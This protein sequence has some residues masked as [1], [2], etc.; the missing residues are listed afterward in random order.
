MY[1]N[2]LNFPALQK[3]SIV[4][5]FLTNVE[6]IQFCDGQ[7]LLFGYD[8]SGNQILKSRESSTIKFEIIGKSQACFGDTLKFSTSNG[9]ATKWENGAVEINHSVRIV[10]DTIIKALISSNTFCESSNSLV[11]KMNDIPAKPVISRKGD[12]LSIEN[13]PGEIKWYK[14]GLL[15]ETGKKFIITHSVAVYTVEITNSSGCSNKS[16]FNFTTPTNNF[17]KPVVKIFP[18]PAIHELFLYSDQDLKILQISVLNLMGQ[19][20]INK[21]NLSRSKSINISKLEAGIYLINIQLLDKQNIIFQFI[22]N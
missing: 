3:I 4:I 21:T 19:V 13:F 22:K 18:N 9:V 11:V 17:H 1:M 16:D 20:C 12:T 5:V 7:T 8:L 14:D 10:K 2:Y 6:L 15:I